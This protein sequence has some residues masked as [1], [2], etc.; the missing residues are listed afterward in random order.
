ML[1]LDVPYNL[2]FGY[3]LFESVL[4]TGSITTLYLL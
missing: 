2:A 4:L 3:S 1:S